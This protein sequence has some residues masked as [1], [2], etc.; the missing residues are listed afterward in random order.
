MR[1]AIDV[2]LFFALMVVFM[3]A[4]TMIPYEPTIYNEVIYRGEQ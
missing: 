2:A 3:A 4:Y 1:E